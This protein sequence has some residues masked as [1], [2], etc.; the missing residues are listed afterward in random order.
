MTLEIDQALAAEL[1]PGSA[2]PI[3][4]TVV[5][6]E[7]AA[8]PEIEA[9]L[10]GD[11]AELIVD[12]GLLAGIG[13]VVERAPGLVVLVV[14]STVTVR[15]MRGFLRAGIAGLVRDSE[16]GVSLAAT[17]QAVRGGQ[18]V[19]PLELGWQIA[20]PVLSR[21]QKQVLGLVV[22]GL[23]N[24][25]IAAKLHLSEHTVKC[26]LYSGFRKLGVSS[27]DEA[28]ATILDPEG[29]LGTG[30]LSISEAEPEVATHGER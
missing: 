14:P 2:E 7:E 10:G 21:R 9:A 25:E 5:G 4:V 1:D 20:K 24:G 19:V 3:S 26:H 18:L 6:L 30:I 13:E 27:R 23:S 8:L 28:V 11:E 17:V 12:D 22:L 16:I 15:E 29:G